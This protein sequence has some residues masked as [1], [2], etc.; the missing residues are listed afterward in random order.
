MENISIAGDDG[1]NNVNDGDNDGRGED[2]GEDVDATAA[3]DDNEETEDDDDDVIDQEI[4]IYDSECDIV[5]EWKARVE[6][7]KLDYIYQWYRERSGVLIL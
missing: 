3:T 2:G 1:S 4:T 7:T 6:T 5:E